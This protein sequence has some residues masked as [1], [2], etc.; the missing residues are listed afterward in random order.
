MKKYFKY[1]VLMVTCTVAS[2]TFT[3]QSQCYD[4]EF[5]P[6]P[7]CCN[8]YYHCGGGQ[9]VWKLCSTGLWWNQNLDTC[10]WPEDSGCT[11]G[12]GCD[13]SSGNSGPYCDSGGR[14]SLSC[15]IQ[16]GATI[17]GISVSIGCSVSCSSNYYACC[18]M[19]CTCIQN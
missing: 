6:D 14:G 10:D 9:F 15:S 3:A 16:A 1:V 17:L 8:A 4:G 18:T 2:F 12:S 7:S 13:S 5:F 11:G 19:R